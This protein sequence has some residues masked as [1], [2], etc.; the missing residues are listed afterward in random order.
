MRIAEIDPEVV[1]RA[2]RRLAAEEHIS[3]R[4]WPDPIPQYAPIPSVS[5]RSEEADFR[6]GARRFA[7]FHPQI[8][9]HYAKFGDACYNSMSSDVG[10]VRHRCLESQ[11]PLYAFE[12]YQPPVPECKEPSTLSHCQKHP[13]DPYGLG[14]PSGQL[15]GVCQDCSHRVSRG[16][17]PYR[18]PSLMGM[19][20]PHGLL[21]HESCIQAQAHPHCSCHN[22]DERTRGYFGSPKGSYTRERARH[23]AKEI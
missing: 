11:N 4:K 3:A 15:S 20:G 14:C 10:R 18:G 22:C 16:C 1:Y 23:W 13:E 7:E 2:G 19:P 12:V 17:E 6:R 8:I 9:N 21:H 5:N